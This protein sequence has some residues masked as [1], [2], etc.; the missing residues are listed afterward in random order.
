MGNVTFYNCEVTEFKQF[1]VTTRVSNYIELLAGS[2]F[3]H[4][5]VGTGSNPVGPIPMRMCNTTYYYS[6]HQAG[7]GERSKGHLC[8]RWISLDVWNCHLFAVASKLEWCL[9]TCL[10]H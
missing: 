5:V 3:S 7:P 4:C 2:H 10:C 1:N 6:F 8:N 9:C